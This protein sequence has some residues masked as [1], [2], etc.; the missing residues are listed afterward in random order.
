MAS[1]Y[2]VSVNLALLSSKVQD[3]LDSLT[4]FDIIGH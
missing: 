3:T 2:H 4:Q 1:R